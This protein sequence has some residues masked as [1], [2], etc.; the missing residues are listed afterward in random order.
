MYKNLSLENLPDEEWKEI[1]GYENYLISSMGR[2]KSKARTLPHNYF[3]L[4]EIIRK[5][6]KNPRGHLIVDLFS[7]CKRKTFLVSRLVAKSFVENPNNLPDV[8]HILENMDKTNNQHT[9]LQWIDKRQNS[10][11]YFKLSDKGREVTGVRKVGNKYQC[12]LRIDGK[13]V[14]VG[15]YNTSKEAEDVYNV[16]INDTSKLNTYR[17]VRKPKGIH[18]NKNNTSYL[19]YKRC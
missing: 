9:N 6:R 12:S 8:D 18:L 1:P 4:N 17:N 5:Q 11:K 15:T 16:L 10:I 19:H 7:N 2:V 13:E 3:L 14:Y